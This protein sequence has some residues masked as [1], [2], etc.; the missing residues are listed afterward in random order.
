M[1]LDAVVMK[2]SFKNN[3][4]DICTLNFEPHFYYYLNMNVPK[5]FI[6]YSLVFANKMILVFLKNSVNLRY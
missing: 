2:W 4:I 5:I 6:M 3:Y 1:I